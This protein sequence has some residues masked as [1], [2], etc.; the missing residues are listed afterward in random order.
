MRNLNSALC[1][2][3]KERKTVYE[4]EV[5]NDSFQTEGKFIIFFPFLLKQKTSFLYKV[6]RSL[7]FEITEN[8]A[9]NAN[10]F[11]NHVNAT[12]VVNSMENGIRLS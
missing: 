4:N 6:R 10:E 2:R 1:L 7:V 3:G 12:L 9:I 11:Y 8:F 5:S